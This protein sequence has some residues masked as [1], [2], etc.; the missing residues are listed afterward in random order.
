MQNYKRST[1]YREKGIR[2]FQ[3]LDISNVSVF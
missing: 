3:E 1:N 2:C